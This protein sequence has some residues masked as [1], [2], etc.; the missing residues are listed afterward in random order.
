MASGLSYKYIC[1]AE[2][3]ESLNPFPKVTHLP[4]RLPEEGSVVEQLQQ[5]VTG[6]EAL[7]N[8]TAP[9]D[10]ELLSLK[11]DQDNELLPPKYEHGWLKEKQHWEKE[12]LENEQ[13]GSHDFQ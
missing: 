13:H 8:V 12:A 2:F 4:D 6:Y 5:T 3:S 9:V 11:Y 1:F 10:C 7:A